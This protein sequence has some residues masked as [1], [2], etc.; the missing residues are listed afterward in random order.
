MLIPRR[1]ATIF[2]RSTSGELC[3][4]DHSVGAVGNSTVVETLCFVSENVLQL[5]ASVVLLLLQRR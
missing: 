5:V 1:F 4:G 2:M 3:L